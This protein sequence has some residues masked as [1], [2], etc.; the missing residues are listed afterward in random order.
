[1]NQPELY[2]VMPVYNE[3]SS[4]PAVVAE[5]MAKLRSLGPSFRLLALDDDSRDGTNAILQELAAQNPGE[6][7]VITKP[8]SGHGRTCRYGYELA[9]TANAEWIFQIDSDGQ[10]DPQYF[11]EFWHRR[12]NFDCLFGART[13]RD[14]G[15]V[16]AAISCCCRAA[17]RF[18]TG[19]PIADPNVPYR[20]MRRSVL[21]RALQKIPP[22]FELQNIA[23]SLALKRE[24]QVRFAFLPIHFRARRAG[25]A[26]L[27]LYRIL[28]LGWE[29][30]RDLKRI[31]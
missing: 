2:I 8:N 21:E 15:W 26:S 20:L 5:W 31:H 3:E 1:M 24:S 16:R 23:L 18:A 27:N 14:D 13:Q 29:M 22:D 6:L 19:T 25:T 28:Q 4:I 17:V 12:E 30:L 11:A 7:E 9:I 10:C